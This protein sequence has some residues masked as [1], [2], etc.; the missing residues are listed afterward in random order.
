MLQTLPKV[1]RVYDVDFPSRYAWKSGGEAVLYQAKLQ[2]Q[3]VIVRHITVGQDVESAVEYLEVS[4][5]YPELGLM[6]CFSPRII[7]NRSFE[8]SFAEK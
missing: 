6:L 2:S 8:R 5:S 3:L 1:L 7:L 4:V